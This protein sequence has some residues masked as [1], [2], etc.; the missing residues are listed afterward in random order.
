MFEQPCLYHLFLF[1]FIISFL[2]RYLAE[3]AV[4]PTKEEV[5]AS[6]Q[7][8]YQVTSHYITKEEMVG[9]S[10]QAYQVNISFHYQGRG[11]CLLLSGLPGKHLFTFTPRKRWSPPSWQA[12]QVNI[13]ENYL[14]NRA[15]IELNLTD[16]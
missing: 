1:I 10:Q 8:A 15:E 2:L 3:V 7:Q 12:Y 14:S 11:G 9:S 6:S 13:S 5:V 16:C 4:E